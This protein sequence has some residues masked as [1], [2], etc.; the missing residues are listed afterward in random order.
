M[1]TNP[2]IKILLKDHEGIMF[3]MSSSTREGVKFIV[4][5]FFDE[6]VGFVTVK[7]IVSGNMTVNT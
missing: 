7:I 3:E 1:K 6:R 2:S 5:V 4:N